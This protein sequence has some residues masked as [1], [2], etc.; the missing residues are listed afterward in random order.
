MVAG[1][2]N[3]AL[4]NNEMLPKHAFVIA[5]FIRDLHR[6]ADIRACQLV[7]PRLHHRCHMHAVGHANVE[8]HPLVL[9]YVSRRKIRPINVACPSSR[10]CP[11]KGCPQGGRSDAA[12]DLRPKLTWATL[13][14]L[15]EGGLNFSLGF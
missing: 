9:S 2:F 14:R 1:E 6:L 5:Q 13:T 4:R 3:M 11:R 10:T 12:V 7:F 8:L 15:S